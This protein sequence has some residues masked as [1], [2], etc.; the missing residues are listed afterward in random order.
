MMQTILDKTIPSIMFY[1]AINYSYDVAFNF[2]IN[3]HNLKPKNLKGL[4]TGVAS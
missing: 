1:N 2:I 3:R 4:F